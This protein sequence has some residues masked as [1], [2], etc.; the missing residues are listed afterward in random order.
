MWL[1]LC[2]T[3]LMSYDSL[4]VRYGRR[5]GGGEGREGGRGGREA[6]RE[7]NLFPPHSKAWRHYLWVTVLLSLLSCVVLALTVW[8][9]RNRTTSTYITRSHDSHVIKSQN[10]GMRSIDNCGHMTGS[11]GHVIA[12]EP[13]NGITKSP[14]IAHESALLG[15]TMSQQ[16]L[17][18]NS[19]S[20]LHTEVCP[21]QPFKHVNTLS[22]PSIY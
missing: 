10:H 12:T 4:G 14:H 19:E 20:S 1:T 7:Y 6:G 22:P 21:W 3:F 17:E 13:L 2:T 9:L 11:D 15:A 18:S 8:L 16:S 5:E